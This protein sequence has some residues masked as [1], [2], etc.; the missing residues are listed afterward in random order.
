MLI[1]GDAF[2]ES[3]SK[4]I[5]EAIRQIPNEDRLQAAIALTGGVQNL[6]ASNAP[7]NDPSPSGKVLLRCDTVAIKDGVLGP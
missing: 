4:A 7:A 5:G 6:T 1:L 3:E 2:R